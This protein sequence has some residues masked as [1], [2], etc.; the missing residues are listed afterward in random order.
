MRVY[1]YLF[2]VVNTKGY[3]QYFGLRCMKNCR[4]IRAMDYLSRYTA[5]VRKT[6]RNT[7]Q[8]T[9]HI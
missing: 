2:Y 8:I 5:I 4:H 7:G 3:G 1:I 9:L 6:I